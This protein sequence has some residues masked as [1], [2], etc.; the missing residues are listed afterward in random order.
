MTLNQL[1]YFDT[2]SRLENFRAAAENLYISQPSLSRSMS[3]LEEE[4]GI[5]L[6]EKEG[7]GV[8]LTSAGR[9]FA[10]HTSRILEDYDIAI[11]NMRELSSTGG[12]VDIGYVFPIAN[13]Y[14][15][16]MV[17]KF[18][19]L[20]ENKDVTFSFS[21]NITADIISDIKKG[22]LDIGFCAYAENEEDVEFTPIIKQ[23]MVIITSRDH[24]LASEGDLPI[25]TL[26]EY[27]VIGYARD[28]GLGRFTRRHYKSMQIKPNIIFE[29][30]D[31][32]SIQALVREGFGIALVAN[33]DI[34][35]EEF[36]T[37]HSLSDVNMSHYINIAWLKNHYQLPAAKRFIDFMLSQSELKSA[38][39]HSGV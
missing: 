24:P 36:V 15:P 29:C 3:S 33:V 31:E 1:I 2:V 8:K 12:R 6:F 32:N 13:Y 27:P 37:V 9:I 28:S 18:L 7:R 34:L 21:Q 20:P 25:M 39:L 16:H 22:K 17:R 14:I 35:N 5:Q 10:E 38:Q 30:S 19:E 26:L 23:E 11:S 4:L